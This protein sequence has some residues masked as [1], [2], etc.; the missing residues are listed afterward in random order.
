MKPIQLKK[1]PAPGTPDWQRTITAS[2]VPA[3]IRDRFT[4][5]YLGIDY[6]SAFER[7]MEMTGQWEQPIDAKTQ[8]MFDDA[9][10]AEDYAVN[11]WWG[12]FD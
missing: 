12:A 1:P 10:D 7:F 8:A 6:L 4:G 3:M 11:V 2:K 9:H 5:E